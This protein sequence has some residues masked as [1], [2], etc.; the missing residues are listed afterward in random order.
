MQKSQEWWKSIKVR[1]LTV[2]YVRWLNNIQGLKPLWS[3]QIVIPYLVTSKCTKYRN[4]R[5]DACHKWDTCIPLF[6]ILYF[7]T[8]WINTDLCIKFYLHV[9]LAEIWRNGKGNLRA[10]CLWHSFTFF[11]S[12]FAQVLHA[13]ST[14]Q[15]ELHKCLNVR[16]PLKRQLG[17][18]QMS[19]KFQEKHRTATCRE[20]G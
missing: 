19:I 8:P 13:K 15:L 17:E 10:K 11:T 18:V 2:K 16:H 20:K 9:D 12:W 5:N 7:D 3:L 6:C 14:Q 4:H 1:A